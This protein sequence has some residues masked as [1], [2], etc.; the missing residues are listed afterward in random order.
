MFL[1]PIIGVTGHSGHMHSFFAGAQPV[2]PVA[3]NNSSFF[4]FMQSL[5]VGQSMQ[6]HFIL[7][8]SSA[9]FC[10]A[11]LIFCMACIISSNL[12]IVITSLPIRCAQNRCAQ[13][14]LL[15]EEEFFLQ[16]AIGFRRAG[17]EIP[18]LPLETPVQQGIL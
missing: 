7:A 12:S 16:Q 2:F 10:S 3:Q 4:S 6:M 15:G 17:T 8:P 9:A 14:P 5:L 13:V 18:P 1:S 11:S